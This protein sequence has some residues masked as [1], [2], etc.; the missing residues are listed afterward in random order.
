MLVGADGSHSKVRAYLVGE[1]KAK[2]M[3]PPVAMALARCRLPQEQVDQF[4]KLGERMWVAFHPEGGYAFM[5][6]MLF[7][8]RRHDRDQD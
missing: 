8:G 7:P 5:C 4:M 1:E 3:Q 6:G 2:S